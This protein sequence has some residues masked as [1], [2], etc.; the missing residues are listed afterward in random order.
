MVLVDLVVLAAAAVAVAVAAVTIPTL[1]AFL[2]TV[3]FRTLLRVSFAARA[4]GI[5][6]M[7]CA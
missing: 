6:A 2:G 5:T 4:G 1:R 3:L 7:V